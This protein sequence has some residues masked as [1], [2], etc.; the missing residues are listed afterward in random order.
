MASSRKVQLEKY[1]AAFR[2]RQEK[3]GPDPSESVGKLDDRQLRSLQDFVQHARPNSGHGHPHSNGGS[4]NPSN[5][6][7]HYK[8]RSVTEH[9]P[10]SDGP[11][12]EFIAEQVRQSEEALFG[13]GLPAKKQRPYLVRLVNSA[14]RVYASSAYEIPASQATQL[15]DRW[16]SIDDFH[17][18][19][20]IYVDNILFMLELFF[21]KL[22]DADRP[23]NRMLVSKLIHDNSGAILYGLAL[24]DP[25]SLG[26]EPC[27]PE[28]K[29]KL[30]TY[31]SRVQNI[32]QEHAAPPVRERIGAMAG[33]PLLLKP[34]LS[35]FPGRPA[36]NGQAS[37][38]SIHGSSG[39][40]QAFRR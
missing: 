6:A 3:H 36:K 10:P 14:L 33:Q 28:Q 30:E 9:A 27:D 38:V 4:K 24:N 20:R 39:P 34:D 37:N 5:G 2:K 18:N 21:Q 13:P 35:A 11:D 29:Q 25:D 19:R 22:L 7:C 26:K 31:R 32:L 23:E 16:L 12:K 1:E 15:L 40:V 17:K 8:G